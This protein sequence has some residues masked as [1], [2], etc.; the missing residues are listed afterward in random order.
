MSIYSTCNDHELATLLSQGDRDAFA[1][2]YDRYKGVLFVHACRRLNNQEEA[3][4]VIH[5]LFATLWNKREE[6]TISGQLS[7]YLYTA[8]RNRIFKMIGRKKIESAY[9]ASIDTTVDASFFITD[10]KIR[11]SELAKIIEKEIAALPE[12]MREIFILSR[13]QNLNH[14]QIAE[15]LGLSEQTVS[16]Q[17]T[18]ALRILRMRLGIIVYLLY[19]FRF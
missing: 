5:D 2:I 8:V 1:E 3:E 6:L 4:D 19:L 16:K 12:K 17:I 14:K 7:G 10:H 11:E 18:N 9:M 13:Q 15:K